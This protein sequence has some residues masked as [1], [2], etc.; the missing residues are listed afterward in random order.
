MTSLTEV[1]SHGA[2]LFTRLQSSVNLPEHAAAKTIWRNPLRILGTFAI[3]ALAFSIPPKS[4][5]IFETMRSCSARGD[6]VGSRSL[7]AQ[8]SWEDNQQRVLIVKGVGCPKATEPEIVHR[9]HR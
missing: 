8:L 4:A 9:Y 2:D 1:L 3:R 6:R 7:G 5:R